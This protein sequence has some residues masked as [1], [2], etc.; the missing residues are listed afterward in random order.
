MWLRFLDRFHGW[1]HLD[2][3]GRGLVLAGVTWGM[4]GLGPLLGITLPAAWAWHQHIPV[5]ARAVVWEVSAAAAFAA[6]WLRRFRPIALSLL[7]LMPSIR[8]TSHLWT[9]IVWL[10][11]GH[12]DP[13]GW[14][15]AALFLILSGFVGLL[16]SWREAPP[17]DQ[18]HRIVDDAGDDEGGSS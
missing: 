18:I 7:F 1:L 2:G 3:K 4:L 15:R 13:H 12:G 17:M 14:Y 9:W 11:I 5:E 10:W 6:A 8:L 16:A